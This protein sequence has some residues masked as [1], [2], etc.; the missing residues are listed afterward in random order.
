LLPLK[1]ILFNKKYRLKLPF[2]CK[3]T[4]Q[5]QQTRFKLLQKDE[6]V[7][8]GIYFVLRFLSML[9]KMVKQI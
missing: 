8:I 1:Y 4:Y 5:N 2:H 6:N 3:K 7:E 9:F